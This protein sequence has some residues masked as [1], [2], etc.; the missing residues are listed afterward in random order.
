MKSS[1]EIYIEVVVY[2]LFIVF[3]I[4]ILLGNEPK[5]SIFGAVMVGTSIFKIYWLNNKWNQQ[6][7]QNEQ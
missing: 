7:L 4:D 1:I 6:R 2:A 5:Q 3:G